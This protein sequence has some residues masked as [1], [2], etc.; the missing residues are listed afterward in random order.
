MRVIRQ[1]L[2]IS[3]GTVAALLA[4]VMLGEVNMAGGMLVH[5]GSVLLVIANGM[6]LMRGMIDRC[7]LR[8]VGETNPFAPLVHT[9][10][11]K[12]RSRMGTS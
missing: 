9:G 2:V 3:L 4:G 5:E 1:N 6:R 7:E 8:E 12:L 10:N 11:L